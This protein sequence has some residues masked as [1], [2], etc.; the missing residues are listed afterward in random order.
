MSYNFIDVDKCKNDLNILNN[1]SDHDFKINTTK[2][3][4]AVAFC[5]I[6]S[7]KINYLN[8]KIA[9]GTFLNGLHNK[10]IK[11]HEEIMLKW[12]AAPNIDI[13]SC[14]EHKMNSALE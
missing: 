8:E 10:N 11:S 7:L 14:S 12:I 5:K 4:M 1:N 3:P 2:E 13:P 9:E 6:C